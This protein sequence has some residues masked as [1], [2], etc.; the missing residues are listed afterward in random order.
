LV[1][2]LHTKSKTATD[3]R[4]TQ[5]KNSGLSRCFVLQQS[6]AASVNGHIHADIQIVVID[7]RTAALI[8]KIG[9]IHIFKGDHALARRA[10]RQLGIVNAAKV[11]PKPLPRS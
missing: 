6:Q 10:D 4:C 11:S 8:R 9:L 2:S 1:C 7:V 5:T 3:R